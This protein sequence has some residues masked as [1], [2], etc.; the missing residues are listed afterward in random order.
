MI[1]TGRLLLRRWRDED[2]DPYARLCADPEGM[3]YVGGG[4]PLTREHS[5][6][7]IARFALHW[8]ERGFGL[9]AVEHKAS[10]AFIGFVG[11][12]YRDEWTEGEHKTEVAW[13]LA[14]AYWGRVSPPRGPS[15]AC[16]T[17]SK[18]WGSRAS[19]SSIQPE[20]AAS[21]RVAE[22][23]GLTLQGNTDWRGNEVV[24]YAVRCDAWEAEKL[25]R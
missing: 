8:E 15:R 3:R 12:V 7:Q 1:G 6:G 18:S 20:N 23:A 19:I 9:W 21:F 4:A 10:G 13:R 16:V 2:I 11:L 14:S 17:V 25:T 24:R 22:K 5:E